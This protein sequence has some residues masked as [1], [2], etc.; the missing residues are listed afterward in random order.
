MLTIVAIVMMMVTVGGDVGTTVSTYQSSNTTFSWTEVLQIK[1]TE[2]D[3]Y[4]I[5]P[6]RW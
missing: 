4:I 5:R 1:I 6:L 2:E 3:N